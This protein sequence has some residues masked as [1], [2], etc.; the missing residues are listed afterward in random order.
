MQYQMSG[1]SLPNVLPKPVPAPPIA[2]PESEPPRSRGR[3]W[4]LL[5]VL[6][7]AG[8]AYWLRSSPAADT[9]GGKSGPVPT[10]TLAVTQGNLQKTV[11]ITGTTGAEN[12][13]SLISPQLR[14]SRGGGGRDAGSK[15]YS[16]GAGA[17]LVIT[18]NA[19]RAGSS[20]GSSSS[21]AGASTDGTVASSA[22]AAGNNQSAAMQASTS[23]VS[24]PGSTPARS[25]SATTTAAPSDSSGGD[26][27]LGSTASALAGATPGG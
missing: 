13:V 27:A 14:G 19:G 25:S 18:S 21:S 12:F 7:A 1:A 23:R 26:A 4:A 17:N 3:V 11:R 16:A 8:A 22:S 20:V 15:T 6:I 10:R 9:T 5:F 24:K 2:A